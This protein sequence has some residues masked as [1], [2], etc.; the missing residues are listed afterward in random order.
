MAVDDED[1]EAKVRSLFKEMD[2]D[3]STTLDQNEL[4]NAVHVNGWASTV[5]LDSQR[6]ALWTLF[7]SLSTL[8]PVL[9]VSKTNTIFF[10]GLNFLQER[11]FSDK[12]QSTV[13]SL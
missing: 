7:I 10:S 12:F 1:F 3:S 6:V 8:L 5:T 2:T 4:A 11:K 9:I 13:L